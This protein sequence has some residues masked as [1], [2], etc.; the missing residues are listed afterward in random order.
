MLANRPRAA[1]LAA[2]LV[3]SAAPALAQTQSA[4]TQGTNAQPASTETGEIIVTAT[5]RS[6]SLE[7]VPFSINAQTQADIER[8]NATTL[9]GLSRN[10]AGLSIQNLGPGQ[11]Q[12]AIRGVSSGQIVR[13]QPGVKEQVGVY[14]DESVISLSLFTPDLDLF[15]LNRVETLRG[16]Q[17][18]LF[19]S[20]SE[21]GTIRYITNQPRTDRI[22]GEM[23]GNINVAKGGDI[24]G[25][26]KLAVNLPFS[27]KAAIRV[28]GYYERFPGFVDAHHLD[29]TVSKNV[30][31]G[32]REGTRI[33]L[34][35]KPTEDLTITPRIVYQQID[36]AGFNRQENFN[37]YSNPNTVPPSPL[38]KRQVF[39]LLPEAFKDKTL[40]ADNVIAWNV[41]PTLTLT[42]VTTYSN[43][44]ILVSRDASALTGSVSLDLKLAP[45]AVILP[46]NLR[47][48]TQLE[49]ISQELRVSSRG[50]GP[51]QYVLGGFY[52][53]L[54]R[55]YQQRLPTPGYDGFVDQRFGAGTSVAVA[56]GFPLDSPYNSDIPYVLDQYAAFG[57]LSFRLDRFR[58]TAGARYYN[59]KEKRNF[60][61]GGLFANGDN[62]IGDTTKSDGATPRFIVS[63]DL[64]DHVTIN[65]QAAQGFRLGGINDPL[66]LTLCSG[67]AGGIDAQTFGGRPTYKDE[68]LWNY[69]G[70]LKGRIGKLRF[71][72][73]GF[74]NDISNLQVTVDAR[75]CS[76]RI[77][78]NAKKAHS[79]GFEGEVSATPFPGLDIGLSTTALEAKF[80]STTL[81]VTG[82]V[83]GGIRKGNRL[84]SVPE[85]TIAANINY[86]W[87]TQSFGGARPFINASIQHVGSRYTQAADQEPGADSFVSH[88]AFGG[89]SGNDVTVVPTRLPA[90]QLVNIS[91]G[92][93]LPNGLDFNVYVTNAFDQN[94]LLAFDKER[95]G[96]ARLGYDIGQPRV[97]GATVRKHF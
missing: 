55:K 48:A 36:V 27:D 66:N 88:L 32:D 30:N 42:S 82:A 17:G 74:Y 61:S 58:A 24:G 63:Y 78:A 93:E 94:P 68:T 56:N 49:Q 38:G 52:T 7:R 20:G 69:E 45:A 97:I 35:L 23:E 18:T 76:S 34:L 80:D 9:E 44:D 89:A 92:V 8:S 59:F 60:V 67:G 51:F 4:S 6:E 25:S 85:F 57:E 47:D 26:A 33:S 64:A 21:G 84:P 86:A 46:S 19:G 29:G 13:D 10:I 81:D 72:A 87:S 96:R 43:R 31:H 2:L 71:T 40:I 3:A 41:A 39:L 79:A 12:V 37:L 5:K 90:Y 77:V 16:P 28:V 75:S 91:A 1:L 53:H 50:D 70:D 54:D 95:G 65:A 83:L 62:H 22:E 11:S 14:L 73:A 15:D